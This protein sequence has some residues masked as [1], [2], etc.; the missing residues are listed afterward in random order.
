M[1]LPE[2]LINLFTRY[3]PVE[4]VTLSNLKVELSN[5]YMK[6]L[7][8][9]TAKADKAKELEQKLDIVEKEIESLD[10]HTPEY[11][12][13]VIEFETIKMQIEEPTLLEKV[14][15][16]LDKP[17]VRMVLMISFVFVSRWIAKKLTEVKE[18]KK[19]QEPEDEQIYNYPPP[20]PYYPYGHGYM[21]NQPYQHPANKPNQRF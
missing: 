7:D 5:I 14:I 15:S 6:N 12:K 4:Q 19:E 13:K 18:D 2:F 9:A 17:I 10:P 1:R 8:V 11:E 16:W 3:A 21:P 20:P